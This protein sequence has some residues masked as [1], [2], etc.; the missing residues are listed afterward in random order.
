MTME[1]CDF[2]RLLKLCRLS[3]TDAERTRIR[4][5][6]DK[7]LSYFNTIDGI[8]CDKYTPSY[9]SIDIP[10]RKRQDKVD[11][12]KNIGKLLKN[13]KIYRFFVVGPKI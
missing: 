12:F 8:D 1:D 9:Q 4:Q 5:D 6:V 3:L 10:D 7:I 2:E 13:S 11:N